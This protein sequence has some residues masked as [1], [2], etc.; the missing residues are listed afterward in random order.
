MKTSKNKT[1]SFDFS[2]YNLTNK[3]NIN[4]NNPEIFEL[5][6]I[7]NLYTTDF[8]SQYHIQILLKKKI[9]NKATECL[10]AYFINFYIMFY[11]VIKVE[12]GKDKCFVIII[13]NKKII[14][15]LSIMS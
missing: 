9:I 13:D 12:K 2:K 8:L 1:N 6:V 3:I 10:R 14:N 4:I 7:F 11:K 5:N 15:T